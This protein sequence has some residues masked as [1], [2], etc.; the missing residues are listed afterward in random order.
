MSKNISLKDAVDLLR[1][2]SC[3]D[4]IGINT[5]TEKQQIREALLLVVEL[6]DWQ[7]LGICAENSDQALK[8]LVDYLKVFNYPDN[9]DTSH[10]NFSLFPT[11]PSYESCSWGKPRGCLLNSFQKLVRPVQDRTF[12]LL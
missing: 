6:S 12:A 3:N 10:S 8:T 1:R 7:N 11:E 5:E 4:H 9:L 2:Y